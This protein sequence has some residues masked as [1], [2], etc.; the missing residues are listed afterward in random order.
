ML[1]CIALMLTVGAAELP[2][3]ATEVEAEARTLSAQTEVTPTFL[4]GVQDFSQ[5]SEQL[6]ASLRQLGV[7]QD[8]PCIFHGI[9]EDALVHMRELQEADTATERDMAFSALRALL[10]DAILIAPMAAAAVADAQTAHE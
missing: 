3:L 6:S 5:D 7:A 8:L 9:S 2:S 1:T 4:A 10:D